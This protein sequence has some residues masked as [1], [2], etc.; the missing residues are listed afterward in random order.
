MTV[1]S[2]TLDFQPSSP[3]LFLFRAHIIVYLYLCLFLPA[4]PNLSSIRKKKFSDTF[5]A[6]LRLKKNVL[7]KVGIQ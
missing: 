2:V 7:H 1:C 5:S 3:A 4:A 6:V